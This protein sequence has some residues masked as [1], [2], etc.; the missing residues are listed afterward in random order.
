M[1][2]VGVGGV[3]SGLLDGEV[4]PES[5]GPEVG[6]GLR[7]QLGAPHVGVPEGSGGDGEL[8]ALLREIVGGILEVRRHVHVVG[9]RAGAVD[10]PL[11]RAN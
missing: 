9:S 3:S 10:V 1:L 6:F 4:V 8:D 5:A 11:V 2:I 7:D